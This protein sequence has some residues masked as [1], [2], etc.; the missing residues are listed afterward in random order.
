MKNKW[1]YLIICFIPLT[2]TACSSYPTSAGTRVV[3]A[4]EDSNRNS[5]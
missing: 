3:V 2:I 4:G 1:L 5:V